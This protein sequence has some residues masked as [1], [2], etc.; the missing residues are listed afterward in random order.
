M[1]LV[2]LMNMIIL[3]IYSF[4]DNQ[5]TLDNIDQ[6]DNVLVYIYLAEVIIKLLGYGIQAYFREGW[7]IMD[8]ILTV[9]SLVTNVALSLAKLART[10][11]STRFLRNLRVK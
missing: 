1:F 5:T 4:S 9:I 11:K 8:F 3:I 6:I 7:N 10:V 2:V